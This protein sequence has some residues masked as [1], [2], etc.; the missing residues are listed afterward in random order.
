MRREGHSGEPTPLAQTD[1]CSPIAFYCG[2]GFPIAMTKRLLALMLSIGLLHSSLFAAADYFLELDTIP[3]ESTDAKL[4]NMIE[5]EGFSLGIDV[6]VTSTGF[7]KATFSDFSATKRI[8]K[9]SPL[10]YLKSAS[11]ARLKNAILH[12]RK[13]NTTLEYY[14]V[15]LT[16]VLITSV[17]TGGAGNGVSESFTLNF[18]KIET[19]YRPQK[20]DGA[21]DAPIRF[22]WDLK[23]N[24]A[25]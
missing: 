9:A 15:T 8:D 12:V 16:D 20:Q 6:P 4:P 18:L 3:G 21:L 1:T 23:N 11:G 10:L 25:F 13:P 7:G 14:T 22:G 24:V 19:V 5:L 17:R 2:F